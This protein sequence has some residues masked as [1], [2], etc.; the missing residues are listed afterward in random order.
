VNNAISPKYCDVSAFV[1][2]QPQPDVLWIHG[3]ADQIVSDASLVDL[4][5]LGALGAVPGWPGPEVFP[6]QP[7]VTQMRALLDRYRVAGGRCTEAVL[8]C[9]HSPHLERPAEFRSLV[10]GLVA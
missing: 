8:N 9:G 4:G 1:H 3:D 7:M 10:A 6:A 5:H 2:V